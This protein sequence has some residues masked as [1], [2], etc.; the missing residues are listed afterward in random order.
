M[1]LNVGPRQ[2]M[3]RGIKVPDQAFDVAAI[4][5]CAD[6]SV[7]EFDPVLA[8]AALQERV[9]N[10]LALLTC[11]ARGKPATGQGKRRPR[12]ASHP[13]FGNTRTGERQRHRGCAG[14]V[15]RNQEPGHEARVD[16]HRHGRPR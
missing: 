12:A 13:P 5:R 1:L 14:R 3:T 2:L 7:I 4:A 11:M 16:V 8:A 15:E 9:R 10:S 6:R